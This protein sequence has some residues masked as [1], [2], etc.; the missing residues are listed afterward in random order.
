MT[1][2]ERYCANP[3]LR[4]KPCMKQEGDCEECT[5][6]EVTHACCTVEAV[7]LCHTHAVR[8]L[9]TMD[10]EE[11]CAWFNESRNYPCLDKEEA[12]EMVRMA[13]M[14]AAAESKA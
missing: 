12:Y 1:L 2:E 8:A 4:P 10:A 9:A 13:E 14:D 3:A 6:P 11:R 5:Y 7:H